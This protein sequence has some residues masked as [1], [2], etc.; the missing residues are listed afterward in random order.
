MRWYRPS[1]EIDLVGARRCSA[2][3]ATKL[4]VTDLG[5]SMK[6]KGVQ[7]SEPSTWRYR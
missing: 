7:E 6:P 1:K 5:T 2:L 3:A 4:H